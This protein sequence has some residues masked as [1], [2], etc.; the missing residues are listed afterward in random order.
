MS[1][2]VGGSMRDAMPNVTAFIDACRVSFGAVEVDGWIRAGLK[3][4]TFWAAENGHTV[5]VKPVE[6]T[7]RMNAGQWL[8][9]SETIEL[10]RVRRLAA[11]K[12]RRW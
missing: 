5:G 2:E 1:G 9:G 8:K 3:D 11:D 6:S 7:D 10:D 12:G 4:G